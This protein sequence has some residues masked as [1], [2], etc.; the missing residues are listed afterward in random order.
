M[1]H[2]E[3]EQ[4]DC[5]DGQHFF[6]NNDRFFTRMSIS[7]RQYHLHT[8]QLLKITIYTSDP[9]VLG[10]ARIRGFSQTPTPLLL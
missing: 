1:E 9:W 8:L 4:D 10:S 7:E 6:N 3:H 5:E 2:K